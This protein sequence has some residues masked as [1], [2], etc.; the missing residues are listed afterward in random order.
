MQDEPARSTPLAQYLRATALIC[1]AA[2]VAWFAMPQAAHA[3]PKVAA[4]NAAAAKADQGFAA[5]VQGLRGEATARGVSQATFDAAFSGVTLDTSIIKLTKKQA[6]FTKPIWQYLDAAVS[7]GRIDTGAAK[8]RQWRETLARAESQFGVDANIV[9]GIWGMETNFGGFA[10]NQSVIRSLATLAYAKY[11]GTFFRD[12]LLV[13]LEILQQGHITPGEMRGSW[14]GA[15][16]QTQFM[17]SSFRDYAVDFDGDGKRN[18]WTSI[19]DAIGSTAN[20]LK[21]HGWLTGQ[22]WG[23]EVT[24]PDG[25]SPA[26]GD[27][28][29]YAAFSSWAQ[30]GVKRADGEAL[31]RSGEAALLLPAGLGGPAFLVTANFKVIKTYNNSTSYALAVALLGDRI[32]GD[33][34]VRKAW[35]RATKPL[36]PKLAKELQ[37]RLKSAGYEIGDVDGKLGDKARDAISAWQAKAGLPADGFPT[38]AVLERMRKAR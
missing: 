15:M 38:M 11:R 30:R 9:L 18:I 33:G 6:E 32:G 2:L 14:A 12:E 8:G 1:A 37:Q 13:A 23:Y 21:K 5:F 29:G 19:P 31:P 28:S 20:Y 10:G 35:P 25:F 27:Q 24:L 16:G 17:P 36:P 22:S 4:P 34:P 7:A 26:G 3:A